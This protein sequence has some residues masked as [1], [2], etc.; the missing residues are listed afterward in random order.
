MNYAEHVTYQLGFIAKSLGIPN[1]I[2]VGD[3]RYSSFY[4]PRCQLCG[5]PCDVCRECN[6]RRRGV[7]VVSR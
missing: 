7:M 1:R 4:I 3:T 5:K 2:L 6:N